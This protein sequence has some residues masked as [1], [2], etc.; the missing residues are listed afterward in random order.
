V[1]APFAIR[2]RPD[3]V[4]ADA[5]EPVGAPGPA[6]AALARAMPA[7]MPAAPGRGLAAPQPGARAGDAAP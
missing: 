4:P 2:R 1:T 5:A 3:P 6:V 7:G